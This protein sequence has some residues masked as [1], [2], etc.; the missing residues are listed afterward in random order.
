MSNLSIAELTKPGRE[1]RAGKMVEKLTN[2]KPDPFELSNGSKV[3]LKADN[4]TLKLLSGTT[5]KLKNVKSLSFTDPKG[6]EVPLSK[7]KKSKEF[8]GGGGS[9]AGAE[10]TDLAE[11][12]QA[13]YA[14][15][16]FSFKKIDDKTLE[17]AATLA[18]TTAK[19]DEVHM[20]PEDWLNSSINGANCIKKNLIKSATKVVTFHRQSPWVKSLE[21]HVM[22]LNKNHDSIFSDINKW[23]PA[24][25]YLTTKQGMNI[26]FFATT[27][28]VELNSLLYKALQSGDIVGISLKKIV[29]NGSF[30]L[31]NAGEK[32]KEIKYLDYTVG[33]KGFFESKDAFIFF[34]V[35]G[36]IQFRTFPS[37]QGEI[38]GKNAAQGKIGYGIIAKIIRMKFGIAAPDAGTTRGLIKR[39]DPQFLKEFYDLYQKYAK[40]TIKVSQKDFVKKIYEL[41]EEYILSK[42][43]GTQIINIILTNKILPKYKSKLSSADVF[44][45]S[46]VEYASATSDLSG[47]YAKVE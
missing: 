38:K 21:K 14:Q 10:V 33:K 2:K 30:K 40:D 27:S 7:I 11:S 24:D 17:K 13:I 37:F 29:G 44:I 5:A 8:G 19:L 39:K 28:L 35:D 22:E 15:A 36:S 31:Y 41:G 43:L 26:D 42:Y 32:K 25:I 16:L 12:A 47:P 9:G 34:T 46:V 45:S 18:K 6:N 3:V 4:A 23:S 1:W 20:L